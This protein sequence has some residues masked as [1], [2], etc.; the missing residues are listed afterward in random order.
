[1]YKCDGMICISDLKQVF[2]AM[3]NCEKSNAEIVL[4][5]IIEQLIE[6]SCEVLNIGREYFIQSVNYE[7]DYIEWRV[8][9]GSK[10]TKK[11]INRI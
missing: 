10:E 8:N 9:N 11:S 4:G 5:Y 2:D 1:M 3:L 7:Y 6:S